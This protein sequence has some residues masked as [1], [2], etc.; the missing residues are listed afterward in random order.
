MTELTFVNLMAT[1]TPTINNTT[2]TW[3][4]LATPPDVHEINRRGTRLAQRKR[5][6]AACQSCR[7]RKVRCN[8]STHGVPCHNCQQDEFECL[9]PERR[10]RPAGTNTLP[11]NGKWS[12]VWFLS[13]AM[14]SACEM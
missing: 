8:V 4:P 12:E 9:V 7:E 5:A 3:P 11:I 6:S 13:F 2:P 1:L 10:R 14:I